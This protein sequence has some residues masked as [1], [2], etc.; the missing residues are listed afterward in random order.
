MAGMFDFDDDK[1]SATPN[2]SMNYSSN[3]KTYTDKE[4][5]V[6]QMQN[7]INRASDFD[8]Q[9]SIGDYTTNQKHHSK[10][11]NNK[12]DKNQSARLQN[13]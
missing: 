7:S 3:S 5:V 13:T 10:Q 8:V 2:Q 6:E 12:T 11:K 4:L 1:L 9:G